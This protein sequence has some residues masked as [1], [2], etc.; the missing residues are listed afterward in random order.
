MPD[1]DE[2]TTYV[3][4]AETTVTTKKGKAPASHSKEVLAALTANSDQ[5]RSAEDAAITFTVGIRNLYVNV[6]G[7][8]AVVP[9]TWID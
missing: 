8:V 9:L 7:K 6:D 2:T 4:P 3:D 1:Y 5:P